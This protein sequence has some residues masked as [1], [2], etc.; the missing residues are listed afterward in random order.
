MR[1]VANMLGII[2]VL[3]HIIGNLVSGRLHL[4]SSEVLRDTNQE[5][6]ERF[7]YPADT[8][9]GKSNVLDHNEYGF[10]GDFSTSK[11]V[12]NVAIFGRSTPYAGNPPI[13]DMT[14]DKL[15]SEGFKINTFN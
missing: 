4:E 13:I 15:E 1:V 5:N 11:N 6:M 2:A 9:R 10:R 14:H 12:Y 7:P 3:I 8:F